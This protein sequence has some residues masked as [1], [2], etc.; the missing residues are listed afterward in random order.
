MKRNRLSFLSAGILFLLS[1]ALIL[2]CGCTGQEENDNAPASNGSSAIDTLNIGYQPSTHMLPFMTAYSKGMYL[3]ELQPLGVKTIKELQ[4]G[5]G[6]PEMQAMLSGDIDLAYVGAAPFVTA[7][8]NGL[9]G[10][11]VAAV[12]TQGSDLVIR[13]GIEYTTPDDLRGLTIAT[14]PPGTIQDTILR[15]WLSDH[16]IDPAKDLTIKGMGP[17]DATTA[18]IAGQIDAVFLPAPSPTIIK[19]S[20]AGY[21]AVQSGEMYPDHACCVLVASDSMITNH[22]DIIRKII[23]VD[24][25]ALDYNAKN[26]D[27]AAGYMNTMTGM[28]VKDITDS[29]AEWDGHFVLDPY[30]I[31]DSVLGFAQTQHELGYLTNPVSESDLFDFSL[32]D[33][34][35]G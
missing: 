16:N 35:M 11:I 12:Q 34:R 13:N 21:I 33:S 19:N 20:G 3:E 9:Q 32:W 8:A 24:E 1:I 15:D 5:T 18:I 25:A 28:D 23:N 26:I 31:R 2:S 17:G 14:F 22:P 29:L 7:V 4:F 27:E 6:A 30:L 10:K